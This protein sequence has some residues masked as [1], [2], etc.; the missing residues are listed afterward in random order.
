MIW[1]IKINSILLCIY[2]FLKELIIKASCLIY[3]VYYGIIFL[4]PCFNM[5]KTYEGKM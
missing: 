1:D 3:R 4:K 5:K 2:I